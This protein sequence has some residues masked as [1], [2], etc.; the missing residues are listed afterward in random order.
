MITRQN[1][2]RRYSGLH[3]EQ[4]R[5]ERLI[6][7]T[8]VA[9]ANHECLRDQACRKLLARPEVWTEATISDKH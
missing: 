9:R 6:I 5:E 1:E 4:Y 7:L 8:G 3:L 2:E